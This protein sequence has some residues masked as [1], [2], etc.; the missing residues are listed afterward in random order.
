MM[1]G[2]LPLTRV[3]FSCEQGPLL[4]WKP[5]ADRAERSPPV[6]LE[7]LSERGQPPGAQAARCA[8]A[9][10]RQSPPCA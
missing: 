1:Q 3:P 6:R 8:W 5:A 2:S 4:Q 10:A 9:A 7:H